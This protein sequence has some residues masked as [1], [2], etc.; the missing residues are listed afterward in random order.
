MYLILLKAIRKLSTLLAAS[1]KDITKVN[2]ISTEALEVS[3]FCYF[4]ITSASKS[5]AWST[6]DDILLEFKDI[7]LVHRLQDCR[8]P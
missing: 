6:Q 8:S 4:A 1:H 5:R 7:L 2:K 3:I